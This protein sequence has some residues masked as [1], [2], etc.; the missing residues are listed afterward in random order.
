[1]RCYAATSCLAEVATGESY[2]KLPKDRTMSSELTA[3]TAPAHSWRR[4]FTCCRSTRHTPECASA[5]GIYGWRTGA[6]DPMRAYSWGKQLSPDEL[7]CATWSV[8]NW[9]TG[10]DCGHAPARAGG[11]PARGARTR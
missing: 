7:E 11:A 3:P 5:Q 4:W 10:A 9:R 1:M 6:V 8:R 2:I